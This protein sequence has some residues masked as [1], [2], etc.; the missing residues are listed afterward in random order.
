MCLSHLLTFLVD[1]LFFSPRYVSGYFCYEEYL[2]GK[3]KLVK[4]LA[5]QLN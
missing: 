4:V 3:K 1:D 5:S 2:D